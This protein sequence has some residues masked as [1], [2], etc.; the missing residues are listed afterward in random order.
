MGVLHKKPGTLRL[1]FT[2]FLAILWTVIWSALYPISWKSREFPPW[3]LFFGICPVSIGGWLCGSV[4]MASLGVK[5]PAAKDFCPQP[6]TCPQ[7]GRVFEDWERNWVVFDWHWGHLWIPGHG[8]DVFFSVSWSPI[9]QHRPLSVAR[10]GGNVS[11]IYAY[12]PA[13]YIHLS[14]DHE[15]S[16][17]SPRDRMEGMAL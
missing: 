6:R 7:G 2:I 5:H 13:Q 15:V 9:Y 4:D 3:F 14:S 1:K 17:P 10:R 12:G 16:P 8:S 11:A